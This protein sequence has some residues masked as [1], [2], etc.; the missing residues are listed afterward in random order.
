MPIICIPYCLHR[1][2]NRTQYYT[3]ERQKRLGRSTRRP[4]KPERPYVV[5]SSHVD[6][7][8]YIHPDHRR[9]SWRDVTLP[10][11]EATLGPNHPWIGSEADEN[12]PWVKE[13]TD[14]RGDPGER[15][16]LFPTEKGVEVEQAPCFTGLIRSGTIYWAKSQ[17]EH[18]RL[19]ISI[20]NHHDLYYNHSILPIVR[21][22]LYLVNLHSVRFVT[23]ISN[24]NL[25][26]FM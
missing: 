19:H 11:Y 22:F 21:I 1:N 26:P 16:V 4:I 7:S 13:Q 24:Y 15:E 3:D 5:R 10:E 20:P 9:S 17:L 18:E 25:P 12:G 8:D 14:R 23:F 6:F 2:R